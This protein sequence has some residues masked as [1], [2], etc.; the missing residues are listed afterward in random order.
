MSGITELIDWRSR[1]LR[2]FNKKV[3]S[4]ECV[5]ESAFISLVTPYLPFIAKAFKL[6]KGF[7]FIS[8]YIPRSAII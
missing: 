6:A 3:T 7:K 4:D 2:N 5:S 1:L 8:A